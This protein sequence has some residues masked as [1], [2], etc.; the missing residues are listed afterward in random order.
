MTVDR[1]IFFTGLAATFVLSGCQGGSASLNISAQG[2]AGMNPG[3][4]GV[5]RPVTIMVHQLRSSSAFDNADF[6]ALQDPAGTLAGDLI[7]TDQFVLA[8]GATATKVVAIQP[9]TT[10]IGITAGFLD[11]AGKQFR[12]KIAAPKSSAGLIVS[13]GS[14]GMQLHDT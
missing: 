9:D 13:V 6:F 10:V 1:R 8:P 7:K 14:S 2:A 4:D 11:P 12:A 5:D 3:T